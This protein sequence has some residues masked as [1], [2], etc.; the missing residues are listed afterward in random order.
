MINIFNYID[1]RK[2]LAD[3]YLEQKGRNHAFSY[4]FFSNKLGFKNKGFIFN[5][6]SNRKNLSKSSIVK[7]SQAIN[8]K[9]K[10]ADYFENLVSFNQAKN[11]QERKYYFSKLIEIKSNRKGASKIRETRKE[12]YEF[13]SKWYLSVIRSLIDMHEFK[14]DYNRLAKNVY[15]P[16]KQKEAKKAVALLEKLG[17]IQKQKNGTYKITD[18]L[19]TAGKEIV[20]LG[21]LNFQLETLELAKKTI[22]EITRD[23]RHISG[24]TLGIS[25]N[26]YEL[27]C[28]EIESF[29][30]KIMQLAELD[31]KAD[32]VFQFNF[33]L[34]PVSNVNGLVSNR[35]TKKTI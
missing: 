20:E 29:Q 1:Y 28:E 22:Q 18:K 16:I 13:Y 17:M 2:F 5:V 14:D 26:T 19:I 4:Q 35:Q 24:L 12:Q 15:P 32:N 7:I 25:K 30:E 21:L 34:F 10:E 8:L 31:E 3:Y 27:I 23:K 6:I 11:L 33:Y 9:P